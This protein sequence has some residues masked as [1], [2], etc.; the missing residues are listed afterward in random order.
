MSPKLKGPAVEESA[1]AFRAETDPLAPA[2]DLSFVLPDPAGDP[3][4]LDLR[5]LR[6]E[7][8]H[9][10]R[11]RR[12][13][14][15]VA[16]DAADLADGVTV[17]DDAAFAWDFEEVREEIEGGVRV[18]TTRQFLFRGAP[19]D[20][21]LVRG[22]RRERDLAGVPLRT[23]VRIVDRAGL[24]PGTV[25][26]YT[27]FAGALRWYSTR[28]QASA[29]ATAPLAPRLFALV[30]RI[31][32]RRD[33]ELPQPF[34]VALADQGK[35]QLERLVDA[36]DMHAAMLLGFVDGLRDLHAPRRADARVLGALAH[37][38]GWELKDYL[39]E[40]GQRSEIAFAPEVYRTI[41]TLP[42]LEAM[43]NRLTGWDAS[44]HEFARN[45]V[46]TFD[47]ARVEQLDSTLAYLDGSVTLSPGPALSTRRRPPGTIDTTDAL[48][49]FR[50]RNRTPEDTNVYTYDCGRPN[51]AG[52]YDRDD[53]VVFD[54]ETI[55]VYVVPDV[56]SEP[57]E[58]QQEW[59]RVRQI[60]AG[61]V[62]IPVRMIFILLP[63]V[64]DETFDFAEV[65][66][67]VTTV[68]A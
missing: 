39:D 61:F 47:V 28:T 43:I 24:V 64:V 44:V 2:I 13:V 27:A 45:V 53:S 41:G 16:A 20:R 36:V 48:G 59:D 4:A 10:G 14:L 11:R 1:L 38:I 52:G 65:S 54:R 33:T 35:G 62:G 26:Y 12:G 55:G 17:F 18:Q 58:L 31:D 25:Y 9:P 46:L 49:L 8:R 67:D 66:E 37:M 32:Q 42:N 19:R 7:R 34:S 57:L 60:L 22:I 30:P 51:A 6:R 3:D 21:V 29:L 63:D 50:L 56:D 5:V 23:T 15:W 68:L 40:D